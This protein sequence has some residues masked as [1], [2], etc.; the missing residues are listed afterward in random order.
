MSIIN[1]CR[2]GTHAGDGPLGDGRQRLQS[3][4]SAAAPTHVS[5]EKEAEAESII[6]AFNGAIRTVESARIQR[7]A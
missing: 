2:C 4:T 5:T 7:Q 1:N 6:P 3:A